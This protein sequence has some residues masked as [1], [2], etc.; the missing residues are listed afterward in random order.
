MINVYCYPEMPELEKKCADMLTYYCKGKSA[1]IHVDYPLGGDLDSGG[2]YEHDGEIYIEAES[3]LALAHELVHAEQI[4]NGKLN[5]NTRVWKGK[6]YTHTK[7]CPWEQQ[8]Y[9]LEQRM[10]TKWLNG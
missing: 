1:E 10:N 7:V 8:A 6:Y 9:G 4:I 5:L 2:C 3:L